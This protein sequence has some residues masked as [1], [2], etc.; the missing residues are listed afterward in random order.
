MHATDAAQTLGD[1]NALR[2]QTRR[3]LEGLPFALFLF[4]SASVVAAVVSAVAGEEVQG[5]F[6]FIAGPVG[7]I[8]VAVHYRRR[9]FDLGL[10]RAGWPYMVTAVALVIGAS[11]L[12]FAFAG[13][14]WGVGPWLAVSA[15]YVVFGWLERSSAVMAMALALG[16]LSVAVG[17][18][19]VARAAVVLNALY[20]CA[21][22]TTG[23]L[24][25]RARREA[26]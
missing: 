18:G 1:L 8:A 17:L 6:W 2:R 16:A 23:L 22:L 13:A 3:H 5:V 20:G 14:L 15:G 4:G 25:S 9:E 21:F 12:G 11:V 19:G 24:L 7:G 10:S 26:S